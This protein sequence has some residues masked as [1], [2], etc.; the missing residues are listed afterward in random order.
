MIDYRLTI[1]DDRVSKNEPACRRQETNKKN[2]DFPSI[3]KQ[4]TENEKR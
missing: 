3:G 2:K 1:S 4:W